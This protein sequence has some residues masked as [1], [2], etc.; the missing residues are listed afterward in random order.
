[1]NLAYVPAITFCYSPARCRPR[2]SIWP[3][4]TRPPVRTLRAG[5][6][7]ASVGCAGAAIVRALATPRV[8]DGCRAQPI[9]TDARSGG[10]E[11]ATYLWRRTWR[12]LA[13]QVQAGPVWA[14]P[15]LQPRL[16][17]RRVRR[18]SLSTWSAASITVHTAQV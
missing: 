6:R 10:V 9:S 17:V 12:R 14:P 7:F 13:V 1:V 4:S 11:T 5:H 18:R 16:P 8:V 2:G 15:L 3:A